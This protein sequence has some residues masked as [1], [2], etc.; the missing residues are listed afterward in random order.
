MI[1]PAWRADWA[2]E[3]DEEDEE[4]P[5]DD[6]GGM[7][8]EVA[9]AMANI[10]AKEAAL[11]KLYDR[12]ESIG[13]HR[14]WYRAETSLE[15]AFVKVWQQWCFERFDSRDILTSLLARPGKSS[16]DDSHPPEEWPIGAATERDYIIAETVLQWLGTNV[17]QGYMHEVLRSR[18]KFIEDRDTW[19]AVN[20]RANNTVTLLQN[21]R[22]KVKKLEEQL[23]A[24]S[25][26]AAEWYVAAGADRA[27]A[28]DGKSFQHVGG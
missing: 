6:S 5:E 2:R 22:E 18:G 11:K 27:Y 10:A 14:L 23:A 28:I 3:E 9:G 26:L 4:R 15:V 17:G 7:D 1:H 12:S 24:V 13:K 19:D 8:A 20:D 25:A 21:E 16:Q